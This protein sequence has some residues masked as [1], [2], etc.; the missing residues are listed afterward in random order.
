MNKK[1][2]SDSVA[3]L[4]AKVLQDPNASATAKKLAG[5][6]LSQSGTQNQTSSEMES[7]ASLVM[8]S[9]KYSNVSKELAGS[10]LSQSNKKR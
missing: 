3:S 8:R 10:V 1:Q 4:A 9:E 5:S 7:L 6:A 2:T